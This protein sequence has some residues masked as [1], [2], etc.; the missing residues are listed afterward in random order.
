MKCTTLLLKSAI[1]EHVWRKRIKSKLTKSP[2]MERMFQ[3]MTPDEE[4][5]FFRN[6]RYIQKLD[7]NNSKGK[8][9]PIEWDPEDLK[10]TESKWHDARSMEELSSMRQNA[11]EYQ[12]NRE[13]YEENP[14]V[15]AQKIQR[16]KNLITLRERGFAIRAF[17]RLKIAQSRKTQ[18]ICEYASRNA[19]LDARDP[20]EVKHNRVLTELHS[21]IHKS[22]RCHPSEKNMIESS[23][24]KQ[25]VSL[26]FHYE[27]H[28]LNGLDKKSCMYLNFTHRHFLSQ[29]QNTGNRVR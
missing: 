24:G 20:A 11:S 1:F 8:A 21:A 9:G 15:S 17:R 13:E 19:F 28:Q 16:Y 10:D 26:P 18:E 14:D 7:G 2:Q 29:M 6:Y 25:P 12:K 5:E 3:Q 4:N 22:P 27:S 23:Y